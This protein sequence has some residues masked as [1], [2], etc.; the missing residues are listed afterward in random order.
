MI[1][2]RLATYHDQTE[3]LVEHYRLGGMLVPLHAERTIPEV[4]AEIAGRAR[5]AGGDAA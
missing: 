1:A 3:P 2:R 5:R 4:Y